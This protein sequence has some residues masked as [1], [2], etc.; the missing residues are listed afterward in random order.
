M[1]KFDAAQDNTVDKVV[2]LI[3]VR[4]MVDPFGE[5]SMEVSGTKK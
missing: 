1:D 3:C 4:E 5:Y 2:K